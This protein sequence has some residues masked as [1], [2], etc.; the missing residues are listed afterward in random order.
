MS[1]RGRFIAFEGG[2]GTG[3]S[4]QAALLAE[5]L[6]ALLTREPG[7]TGLGEH[8]RDLVLAP[9][10]V[11]VGER[12][13]ALLFAAA[14][15]QHVEEIIRPALESGRHVVTD[16]FLHSSVAYQGYG[17]GLPPAE[18]VDLSRWAGDGLVPDL[19]V[20]LE[21]PPDVAAQRL[22]RPLDR[23]ESTGRAF[24]ER[25]RAGFRTM[26]ENDPGR[27]VV[28]DGDREVDPLAATIA[29][30]VRQRLQLADG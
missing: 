30:V 19:V 18:I 10:G 17:R 8:L 25:V 20:L 22:A 14:R 28:L 4:T 9:D 2:E 21:V 16:R 1:G 23:L 6:G 26:A 15:A 3:K 7:G 24:H 11:A 5:R 29:S 27:W 12:A 13:E